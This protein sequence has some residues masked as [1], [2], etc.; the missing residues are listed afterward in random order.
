MKVY[1][2]YLVDESLKE[3]N[4]LKAVD[5]VNFNA[6]HKK[7]N[8]GDIVRCNIEQEGIEIAKI[9]TIKLLNMFK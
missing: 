3:L 9:V 7:C 4:E 2:Q 1:N 5:F 6:N 8:L